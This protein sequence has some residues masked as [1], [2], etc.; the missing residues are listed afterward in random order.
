[1]TICVALW[2]T[3]S[4]FLVLTI[5]TRGRFTTKTNRLTNQKPP[6]K[7]D[8]YQIPGMNHITS[9]T[10]KCCRSSDPV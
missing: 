7:Q 8:F 2:R 9:G 3:Q 6:M 5:L 4:K 10:W 1:M